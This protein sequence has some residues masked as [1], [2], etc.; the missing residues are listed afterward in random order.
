MISYMGDS[1]GGGRGN[2]VLL[3]GE[4]FKVARSWSADDT[5]FGEP[6]GCWL[7]LG[8]PVHVSC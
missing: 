5:P 6:L 4:S 3:D 7:G 2:F 1:E 8:W